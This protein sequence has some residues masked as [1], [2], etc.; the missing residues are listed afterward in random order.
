MDLRPYQQELNNQIN[1]QWFKQ[2]LQKVMLQLP[3]GGGKT[4]LFAKSIEQLTQQKKICLVLVHREELII[5]AVDKLKKVTRKKIGI[6]KAG[7]QPNYKAKIQVASVQSLVRRLNHLPKVDVII[8]DEAHHATANSYRKCVEHYP[9]SLILGV[10]ATPIRLDATGFRDQFEVLITGPTIKE[11]IAQKYL[12]R[13]RLFADPKPMT[14]KGVRM[15][16]GDFSVEGL[17]KANNA[18]ELSGNL[19]E[20][21][22]RY[23]FGQQCV[24]FAINV[25][26]S[27]AIAQRYIEAGITAAHLDGTCSPMTRKAVLEQ[28]RQGQIKVLTNCALFDEGFD[29]PSLGAIQIAKPT[30]SLTRHLQMAGR[31]LRPCAGKECAIIIDHTK[32]W[33]IHGLPNKDREWTLDGVVPKEDKTTKLVHNPVSG[34]VEEIEIIEAS[35]LLEEIKEENKF[36][37]ISK[38]TNTLDDQIT[39]AEINK[40]S[41]LNLFADSTIEKSQFLPKEISILKEDPPVDWE[42]LW[43]MWW[44]EKVRIQQIKDY[45][46]GWLCFQLKEH[47]APQFLWD[48]Y[49]EYK[50]ESLRMS[51]LSEDQLPSEQLNLLDIGQ[52]FQGMSIEKTLFLEQKVLPKEMLAI[53]NILSRALSR[54]SV[55]AKC[56]FREHFKIVS[57]EQNKVV[58]GTSSEA[59]YKIAQSRKIELEL[60]LTYEFNFKISLELVT[61]NS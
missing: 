13:F 37:I 49:R 31:V 57:Y 46:I 30:A 61:I 38:P 18:Y 14:T 15:A 50:K 42:K 26:H 56:L 36:T 27:Q 44:S 8:I 24:V 25:E 1:D 21:Y 6:I 7:Y 28:F 47:Y 55:V 39:T 33:A 3:T 23:A 11:L 41:P 20:S 48:K 53:E 5:Q 40:D 45:K 51:R 22:R 58:L 29:L 54:I 34:E 10:T 52:T 19:V 32:N 9:D 12:S 35:V 2:G 16:Q 59:I 17:A 43:L 4:V 60:A